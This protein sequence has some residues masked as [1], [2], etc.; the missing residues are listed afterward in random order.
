MFVTLFN[1]IP[2]CIF[3]QNTLVNTIWWVEVENGH[4][5]NEIQNCV[6][7][8]IVKINRIICNSNNKYG[9]LEHR[10]FD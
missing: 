9:F 10:G 4:V 3:K 8:N 2:L 5:V 1:K 6:P 7:K